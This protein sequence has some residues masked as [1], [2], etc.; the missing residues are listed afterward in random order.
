MSTKDKRNKGRVGTFLGIPYDWRKP[1]LS[2][3]Q[4]T[5]WKKNGRRV[6]A[7]KVFGWGYTIN[8]YRLFHQ[9]KFVLLALI[10]AII[11]I[12]WLV[13]GKSIALKRAH[14]SFENYYAFRG[15]Q[16]LLERTSDYGVCRTD[17]GAVIKIVKYQ[18]K[19]YLD[20]DLP[21]RL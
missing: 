11:L 1:S 2:K 8:F 20:G 17:S 7:P 21:F 15:C 19:W 9:K 5:G 16:Q 4:K 14:S 12:A 18:D 13:I 10:V 3:Y 6:F